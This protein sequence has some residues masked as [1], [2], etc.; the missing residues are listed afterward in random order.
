M[1]PD[2]ECCS[3]VRP[4]ALEV[5]RVVTLLTLLPE[6]SLVHVVTRMTRT[7]DHRGFDFVLRTDVAVGAAHLCVGA[8]Q[9]EAGVGRVVEV[10]HLPAVRIV[11]LGTFLTEAAIVDI[12]LCMAADAFLGGVV[13]SLRRMTLAARDNHV[14]THERILRLVV[15][16]VHF[17][18]LRGGVALFALLA[19]CATV[20]FVG[21]VAV[22]ALRAQLLV[23][24]DARVARVTVEI[25]VR[26]LEG[27]FEA[28]KMIEIGDVPHIVP[29]AIRT[30]GSQP[31]C[32]R[33]CPRLLSSIPAAY[34]ATA[35]PMCQ[36]VIAE[37][38]TPSSNH[39]TPAHVSPTPTG[40][41][42]R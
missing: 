23:F 1:S 28:R 10:P 38:I 5:G 37:E 21:P 17:H 26:A 32:A 20:R 14:Q 11:T 33:T 18:P 2:H 39:V 41:A 16:E 36:G 9:G 4:R 34:E 15:I 24:D 29:V 25:C 30:R 22:D 7:A 27:K 40:R 13:E 3:L 35:R 42:N 6:A 19:Q 8:Q 12:V 31:A